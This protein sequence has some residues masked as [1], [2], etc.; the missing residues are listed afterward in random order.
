[1]SDMMGDESESVCSTYTPSF[2]GGLVSIAQ[3]QAFSGDQRA[4]VQTNLTAD[5]LYE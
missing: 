4:A 1:M 5:I 3:V 2:V